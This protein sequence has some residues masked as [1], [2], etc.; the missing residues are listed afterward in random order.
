MLPNPFE[1]QLANRGNER[2]F[3]QSKR[4]FTAGDK[5]DG[6]YYVKQGQIRVYRMDEGGK[7]VEMT[8][9]NPGDHFGEVILFSSPYFP[10]SAEAVLDSVVVYYSKESVM[11]AIEDNVDVALFFL[12]LLANKC[13]TLTHKI[14]SIKLLNIRQRLIRYLLKASPAA[15]SFELNLPITKTEL[16]KELGTINETLSRNLQQLQ[17]ERLL[18]VSG[19]KILIWDCA[20]L[21]KSW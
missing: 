18:R 15:G 17:K 16:A 13:R 10:V 6:F 2:R 8:R 14:E 9:L 12:N 20:K 1:K 19:K 11:S 21:R 3:S 5:A 7:E 4:L